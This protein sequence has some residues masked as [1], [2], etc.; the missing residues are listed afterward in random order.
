MGADQPALTEA[1]RL[2]RKA[3]RLL[4]DDASPAATD[5][6][7]TAISI[8]EATGQPPRSNGRLP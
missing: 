1:L 6:L 5:E 7:L 3:L 8:L 2:L 4:P